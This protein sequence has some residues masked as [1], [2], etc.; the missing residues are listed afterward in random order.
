MEACGEF[1][2]DG[3]PFCVQMKRA[4]DSIVPVGLMKINEVAECVLL[5]PRILIQQESIIVLLAQGPVEADVVGFPK[6]QVVWGLDHL[7]LGKG[8]LDELDG[9]ICG[10]IVNDED[11]G[12]HLARQKAVKALLDVGPRIVGDDDCENAGFHGWVWFCLKRAL[13]EVITLTKAC[14]RRG[15][16]MAL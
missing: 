15:R 10:A 5:D 11:V 14:G 2:V 16:K 6:A 9:A 1:G 12:F 8:T 4:Q 7:Q 3:R 13:V